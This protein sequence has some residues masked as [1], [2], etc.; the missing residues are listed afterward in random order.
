MFLYRFLLCEDLKDMKE[1]TGRNTE[2]MSALYNTHLHKY[3]SGEIAN[4]YEDVN[5]SR[6]TDTLDR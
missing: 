2:N 6:C 3:V 5:L 4:S 1:E